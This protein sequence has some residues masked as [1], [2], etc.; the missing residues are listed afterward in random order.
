[1]ARSL[2]DVLES[3]DWIGPEC[4]KEYDERIFECALKVQR[5]NSSAMTSAEEMKNAFEDITGEELADDSLVAFPFR[6]DL[7]FNIHLGKDVIVNYNCT[8]L[9]T[10]R[11]SVDDHT[12]IGPDCHFVT[13]THPKDHLERREHLVKG[14]P[15]TIGDDCWIGA[16]VTIVPG[17]TIGD[18]CIIGAGSVVTK[19]VPDDSVYAG[20]PAHPIR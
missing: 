16:N 5:Y 19:D 12:K 4:K 11:I 8:F 1:M 14:E 18:R 7:G 6:C 9:D 10:A 3:G 20:N 15:I 13:A 17:V 2:G